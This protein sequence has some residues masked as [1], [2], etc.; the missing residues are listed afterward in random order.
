MKGLC[1]LWDF[2]SDLYIAALMWKYAHKKTGTC[3]KIND[4]TGK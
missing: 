1:P 2:G 3:Y 4:E